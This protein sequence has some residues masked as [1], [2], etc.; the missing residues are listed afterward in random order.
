MEGHL[1]QPLRW[2]RLVAKSLVSEPGCWVQI[3][4]LL[5]PGCVT[6]GEGLNLSVHQFHYL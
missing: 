5:F 1:H 3:P 6:L 4:T 2:S